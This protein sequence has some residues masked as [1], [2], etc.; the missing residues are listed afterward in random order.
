MFTYD[1]TIDFR[2]F[3]KTWWIIAMSGESNNF[4]NEF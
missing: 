1:K 2:Y 3:E 4:V